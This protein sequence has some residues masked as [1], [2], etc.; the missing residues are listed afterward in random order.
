MLPAFVVVAKRE[1]LALP[2]ANRP[3]TF[4]NIVTSSRR[5]PHS[6]HGELF[7]Y[8]VREGVRSP[9]PNDVQMRIPETLKAKEV[10]GFEALTPLS[11]VLDEVIPWIEHEIDEGRI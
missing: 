9:Y 1:D 6:R 11:E 3:M 7:G 2:V 8:L 10:L 5:P 4:P